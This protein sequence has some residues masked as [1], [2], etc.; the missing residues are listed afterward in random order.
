ME[1]TE[2]LD[3]YLPQQHMMQLATLAGDQP[4]CCT[5][6]YVHDPEHNLYWAS[7]PTRRHSQEIAIHPKVAAAIAIQHVKGQPVTGLQYEGVAE[8]LKPAPETRPI[9][10]LYAAK[11]GRDAQWVDD[12][13]AGRTQHR[14]Y[15]LTPVAIQL[16][17][18][19]GFPENP[20]Q[21]LL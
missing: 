13:V 2:I 4:W 21:K 10:E 15:K 9:A 16:F 3:D 7:L 1:S 8:M 12:I 6:Y 17:D 20:E 14:L 11:F 5:V 18:E 19:A